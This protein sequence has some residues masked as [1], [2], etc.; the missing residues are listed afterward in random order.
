MQLYKRVMAIMICGVTALMTACG[1]LPADF[2]GV[3]LNEDEADTGDRFRV[4]FFYQNNENTYCIRSGA[5]AGKFFEALTQ[6]ISVMSYSEEVSKTYVLDYNPDASKYQLAE[7]DRAKCG[8][9]TWTN[10]RREYSS[11]GKNKNAQESFY[12][13]PGKNGVKDI[14]PDSRLDGGILRLFTEEVKQCDVLDYNHK[15][16]QNPD[17]DADPNAEENAPENAAPETQE[18]PAIADAPQDAAA[19]AGSEY[20]N[21]EAINLVFTD[22]SERGITYLGE[23]LF[24]YYTSDF[25]EDNNGYSACVMAIKLEVD[26]G[27]TLYY[28]SQE[29]SEGMFKNVSNDSRWYYLLMMG[30]CTKLAMFVQ[31]LV[32]RMESQNIKEGT[33]IGGYQI[34]DLSFTPENFVLDNDVE[35]RNISAADEEQQKLYNENGAD[36]L[37]DNET[38]RLERIS[39]KDSAFPVGIMRDSIV[40]F[41]YK[42]SEKEF[43]VKG[44]HG[45]STKDFALNVDLVKKVESRDLVADSTQLGYVFGKP[46]IYYQDGKEWAPMDPDHQETFFHKVSVDENDGTRLSIIGNYA[47]ECDVHDLYITVP[48]LQKATVSNVVSEKKGETTSWVLDACTVKGSNADEEVRRT[49][50]FDKFYINLLNLK[51]DGERDEHNKQYDRIKDVYVQIDEMKILIEDIH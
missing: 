4:N 22:L 18:T 17:Q 48:I 40:E 42:G 45:K 34:S 37:F 33:Q 51:I 28:S 10:A 39:G 30:P 25:Y 50:Y 13:L 47:D 3:E 49:Y 14:N 43:G 6:T 12:V 7:Y 20:F 32:D 29:H 31:K 16:A 24:R 15:A 2:P 26:R 46:T 8:N 9:M 23:D 19:A 35:F 41:R 1:S 5:V 21:P 44:Y 36:G 11:T 38:I 27:N